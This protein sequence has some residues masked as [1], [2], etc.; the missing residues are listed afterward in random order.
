MTLMLNEIQSLGKISGCLYSFLPGNPHPYADF[1]ISFPGVAKKM[2][3]SSFWTGESKKI[4][5]TKLLQTTLEFRRD[6]FCDLILEIVKTGIIYRNNKADPIRKEEILELNSLLEQVRFKIPELWDSDFL[7]SLPTF[8]TEEEQEKIPDD[9]NAT[10][11]LKN[12]LINLSSLTPQERGFAFEK[13][14][15][16]MFCFYK[17]D[18]RKPFKLI[19]EQIDGSLQFSNNTY[20]VEAK[21]QSEPIGLSDL[22]VFREKVESKASWSRGLFISYSCFTKDGLQAFSRGRATN[23]IGMDGQD[24]FFVLEGGITLNEAISKKTRWAAETGEFYKSI[25]SLIREY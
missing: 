18:P 15:N 3:L 20:L 10:N 21:W 22:I 25:F 11:E 1:T 13:F 5:I 8:H 4:A 14:L 9:R 16:K 7:N 12:D 23:L 19:G 24:L 6:K 17:L 2:G